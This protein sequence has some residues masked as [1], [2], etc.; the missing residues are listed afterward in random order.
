MRRFDGGWTRPMQQPMSSRL[1][2]LCIEIPTGIINQH[3]I[4]T[5]VAYVLKKY[6]EASVHLSCH[7]VSL[8]SLMPALVP[9]AH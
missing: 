1:Q 2:L 6:N 9:V 4:F 3:A 8:E 7:G 5:I